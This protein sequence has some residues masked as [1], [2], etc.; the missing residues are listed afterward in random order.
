MPEITLRAANSKDAPALLRLIRALAAYE[1]M[2][3]DI[4]FTEAEVQARLLQPDSRTHTVIAEAAGEPIGFAL[5]YYG[6]ATFFDVRWLVIEAIYVDSP[7]R[8]LGIGTHILRQLAAK[9]VGE[10]CVRVEWSVLAWNQPAIDFY[11]RMG[12]TPRNDFLNYRLEGEALRVL[13]ASA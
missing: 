12:A 6:A 7:M 2:S 11:E 3:P 5:Y 4:P 10:G 8:K 9:A 1:K 13:A